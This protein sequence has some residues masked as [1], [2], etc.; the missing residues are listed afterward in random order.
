MANLTLVQAINLALLQE[1]EKDDRVMLMGEDIGVNG[2]VFRVTEGLHERFGSRRVVDTPLAESGI[3]GTAIGLAMGGLRPI[4]EIQF[5]GFLAPA[6]DQICTH[7]ARMRSRTRAGLTAPLTIRVPVGG[8][9]HAPELHS[10]SPEAI[11]TH[12]PGIKVVMPSSPYDAKGL[13]ISAIRDPD[14]VIF[15]EPKRIYR[16]FR[17]EVPEDEYTVPIGKARVVREG[18]EMTMVSW[19]AT[20]VQC[21]NAIEA[22]GRDIELIDLRTINPF[23]MDTV[24]TSVCKTGRAVIVH[25]APMSCG[26]GAELSARIMEQCFLRLEA[27]VQRVTGF[28]TIMPYYKL[29]LDYMPDAERIGKAISETAAY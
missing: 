1:M 15:F 12:N 19:G 26:I 17:E 2:G 7:A 8:G 5:E 21:M 22:S 16:A 11:F 29:E 9:I 6:Y 14:P 25:E 27:P 4:P 20:V 24:A 13:L 28:D 3:I 23:D 10:D 18:G